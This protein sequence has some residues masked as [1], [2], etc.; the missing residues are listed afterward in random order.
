MYKC[1]IIGSS[2]IVHHH[3]NVLKKHKI[4]IE[5]ITSTRRNS[6]NAKKIKN[7]YQIKK[8]FSNYEDCIKECSKIKNIFFLVCTRIKDTTKVLHKILNTKKPILCEKPISSDLNK[9]KNLLK[10]RKYIYVGYN[11]IFYKN[12][13]FLKKKK[14]NNSIINV[15]CPEKNKKTFIN[16]SCHIISII[17]FVFNKIKLVKKIK[18]QN[19]IQCTFSDKKKKHNK[20]NN[21][22]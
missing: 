21:C 8:F 5:A 22:F 1:C 16:N 15:F 13:I 12:I 20:F 11:R 9:L 17:L 7:R 6:F 2:E 14:I 18:K 10:F 19:Y 3:I 4:K